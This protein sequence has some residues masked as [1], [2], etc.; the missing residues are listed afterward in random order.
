[1]HSAR[2]QPFKRSQI[3]VQKSQSDGRMSSQTT[4]Y[5]LLRVIVCLQLLLLLPDSVSGVGR[6]CSL[7]CS[8]PRRLQGAVEE[9]V[10]LGSTPP[11]CLNRCSACEPCTA[12]QV[13]TLP[14]PTE[15]LSADAPPF[16]QYSS[17][18]KPLEWKCRCGNRFF[19]P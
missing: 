11:R 9:K 5:G 18:Y 15:L 2:P 3:T 17:N 14:T 7:L 4:I 13:P 6:Q 10:R 16:G 1:M 19:N 12:V 8:A